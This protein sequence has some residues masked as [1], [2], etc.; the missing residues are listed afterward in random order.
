[1]ANIF[2]GESKEAQCVRAWDRLLREGNWVDTDDFADIF[3]YEYTME[4][5]LLC[6]GRYFEAVAKTFEEE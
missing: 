2:Q 1:M 5:T 4:P 3:D 6:Y